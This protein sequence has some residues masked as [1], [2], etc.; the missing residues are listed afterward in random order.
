MQFEV[1]LPVHF[2]SLAIKININNRIHY[3]DIIMLPAP[4]PSIFMNNLH[5]E[6][7]VDLDIVTVLGSGPTNDIN[8]W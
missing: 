2:S 7:G 5:R 1:F 6:I 3:C 4:N 8:Y